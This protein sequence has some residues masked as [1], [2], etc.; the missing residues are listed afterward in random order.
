[1]FSDPLLC[2]VLVGRATELARLTQ[3]LDQAA[4]GQGQVVLLGGEGSITDAN[5][6]PRRIFW[7]PASYSRSQSR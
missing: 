5:S 2:P 3:L 6:T 4:T 7:P 1:M